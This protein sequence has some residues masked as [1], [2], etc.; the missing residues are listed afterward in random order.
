MVDERSVYFGQV[1]WIVQVE[2]WG[3]MLREWVVWG[4]RG[5]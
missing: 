2:G 3:V 1:K 5:R 4:T